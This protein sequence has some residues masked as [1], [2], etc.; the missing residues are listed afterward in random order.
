MFLDVHM[1]VHIYRFFENG[2]LLVSSPL[3][4][5]QP[6][7]FRLLG[8]QTE[9]HSDYLHKPVMVYNFPLMLSKVFI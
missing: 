4:N 3:G 1:D 6:S 8:K 9:N 5:G 2:I 7:N